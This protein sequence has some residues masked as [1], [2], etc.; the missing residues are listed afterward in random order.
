ML[1]VV[2]LTLLAGVRAGWVAGAAGAARGL[3]GA[4]GQQRAQGPLMVQ[5]GG[6]SSKGSGINMVSTI[7]TSGSGAASWDGSQGDSKPVRPAAKAPARKP[8]CADVR[9]CREQFALDSQRLSPAA[10]A[11]REEL[12]LKSYEMCKDITSHYSKTFFMGTRLFPPEKARAVWAVYAWCRRTD[13]IVDK[14]RADRTS[15]RTELQQWQCRLA[16]V[17]AGRPYDMIDLALADTV[18]NYP[19]LSITPCAAAPLPPPRH[20]PALRALST[21][22][23]CAGGL[24]RGCCAWR[25]CHACPALPPGALGLFYPQPIPRRRPTRTGHPPP[26]PLIPSAPTRIPARA[27]P[28]R[29]PRAPPLTRARPHPPLL[30][31]SHSA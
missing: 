5:K 30:P 29:S 3:A 19:G 10:L 4:T 21:L 1:R 17:W 12:L 13:D 15:L 31:T 2:S 6:G 28:L 26:A 16:D 24:G 8:S 22:E 7:P 25:W 20:A 27:A 11:R 14:P 18:K 23:A 9:T